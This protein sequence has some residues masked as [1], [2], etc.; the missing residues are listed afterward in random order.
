MQD[1]VFESGMSSNVESEKRFAYLRAWCE[2]VLGLLREHGRV[3]QNFPEELHYVDIGPFCALPHLTGFQSK[4]GNN[5]VRERQVYVD[6]FERAK[7]K[8]EVESH[9]RLLP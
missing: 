8:P 6:N 3:I 7:P 5:H 4:I 2:A 1:W 9:R